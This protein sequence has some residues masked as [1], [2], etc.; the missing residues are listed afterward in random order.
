MGN[1]TVFSQRRYRCSISASHLIIAHLIRKK[2]TCMRTPTSHHLLLL[3]GDF[4]GDVDGV[5][6]W[7]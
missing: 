7:S 2:Y 4:S 3:I 5:F 1:T 6:G